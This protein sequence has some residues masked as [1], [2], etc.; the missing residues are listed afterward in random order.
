MNKLTDLRFVIGVFFSLL[1]LIL[2]LTG[3]FN[4]GINPCGVANVKISVS[5]GMIFFLFGE[6][7]L[8]I[9]CCRCCEPK[10]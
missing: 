9:S 7:M 1:G 8:F 4:Y 2:V 5:V 6:L 3:I 10:Q